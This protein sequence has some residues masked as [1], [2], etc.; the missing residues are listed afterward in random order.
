[1]IMFKRMAVEKALLLNLLRLLESNEI[2][3]SAISRYNASVS[4]LSNV[5][6]AYQ[7]SLPTL[8]QSR[9]ESKV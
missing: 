3:K 9:T 5:E 8:Q 4:C 1:M 7:R 6:M 2:M